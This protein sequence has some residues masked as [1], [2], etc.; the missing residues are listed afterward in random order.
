MK[1]VTYNLR[2]GG[3]GKGH[4]DRVLKELKPVIE[5]AL[6]DRPSRF[7]AVPEIPLPKTDERRTILRRH[8]DGGTLD[9]RML[10]EVAMGTE[11]LSGATY[12]RWRS[13]PYRTRFSG[14][15]AT[16]KAT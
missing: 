13:W 10:H 3:A 6:K 14:E 9:E 7:D 15:R 11:G 1:I 12:A 8:L 5:P 2:F 16:I 4:W